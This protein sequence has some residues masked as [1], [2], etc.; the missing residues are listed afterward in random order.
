MNKELLEFLI[1]FLGTTL[2]LDK[3][4]VASLLKEDGSP[5]PE[6]LKTLTDADAARVATLTAKGKE[7][8]DNGYKKAEATVKAQFEKELKDKFKLTASDKQGLELIEEIVEKSKPEPGK[9]KTITDDDVMKHPK[10]KE[11]QIKSQDDLKK[12][13]DELNAKLTETQTAQQRKEI[14]DKVKAQALTQLEGMHPILSSDPVK[15]ANQK[16]IFL[17]ELESFEYEM[18]DDGTITVLKDKK[19]YQNAHGHIV[20]FKD[21]AKEIADKYYDYKKAED[22]AAPPADDGKG[23]AGTGAKVEIKKPSS[24]K[25]FDDQVMAIRTNKLLS[26]AD[27]ESTLIELDKLNDSARLE[28]EPK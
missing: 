8:F 16:A 6:A 19:I 7:Q 20:P 22:R 15:A 11:L 23:G 3:T 12:A 10:Y 17:R 5:K 24:R 13:T 4:A 28:Y 25:E 26:D 21:I 9:E 1:A 27:R 14:F 2:N 18:K